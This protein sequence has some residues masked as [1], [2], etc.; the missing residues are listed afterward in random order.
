MAVAG[1]IK[2]PEGWMTGGD[3]VEVRTVLDSGAGQEG[4]LRRLVEVPCGSRFEGAAGPGGELWFVI[5]GLGRLS[6]GAGPPR[7]VR[8]DT[9]VWLPPGGGYRVSADGPDPLRLDSVS[10]P[11][12]TAE[13]AAPEAAGRAGA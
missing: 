7:P 13:G 9:G 1:V 6:A 10:L 8:R 4:L 5:T 12:G 11:G 2:S 3:G